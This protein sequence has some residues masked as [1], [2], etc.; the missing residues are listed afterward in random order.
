MSGRPDRKAHDRLMA[1][2][3]RLLID[4]MQNR[5]L[6]GSKRAL[7]AKDHDDAGR[8]LRRLDG[9]FQAMKRLYR[10]MFG[11]RW[12]PFMQGWDSE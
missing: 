12:T 1:A 5:M 7:A 3:H 2:S 9:E 11:E 10:K 4:A 6:T 8:E